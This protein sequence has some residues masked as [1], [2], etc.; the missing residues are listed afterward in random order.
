MKKLLVLNLVALTESLISKEDTPFLYSLYKY[1]KFFLNPPVPAVTCTSQS[2]ILTGQRANKHGIVA[3]GWY[4][5]STAEVR[6]WRQSNHL[7]KVPK[8]WDYL[9]LKHPEFKVANMFWWF[10][11][12]SDVDY[13]VTPRPIYRADGLKFPETY[14]YPA[15]L[16]EKLKGKLGVFP[17]FNFWGPKTSIKSSHWIAGATEYVLENYMP[18][19][20]FSYIPHL[21]Y[22][23]QRFG[24]KD[25]R[26]RDDLKELDCVV[27]DLVQKARSLSYSVLI[28]SEYNIQEVSSVIHVNKIF[29]ER[30]YLAVREE[31]GE[32]HFDAGASEAFAVADHQI[33]HVYVKRKERIDEV[34]SLLK[35]I[36][37]IDIVLRTNEEKERYFLNHRRSGDIICLAKPDGWFSYYFWLD[38]S[39]APDYARTVDIH[40]KPGYDPVELFMDKGAMKKVLINLIKKKLGFRYLMDVIP[41]NSSLVKG[42]H[43]VVDNRQENKPLLL[44]D[45]SLGEEKILEMKDVF[46]V[47]SNFFNKI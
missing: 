47:I 24:P 13:S 34:F 26:I 41:I 14:S 45:F 15:G 30:G 18:D 4:S 29:R 20:C 5:R 27:G 1:Q 46:S 12:Y 35:S 43:G 2:D 3:N 44:A 7:V 42:S 21:D 38:V 33:A 32:E 6:F 22:N 37:G 28:L 25:P 11:M 8:I 16:N 40:R 39:K 9:K 10:N 17:L 23:L 36:D 19:L 31:C